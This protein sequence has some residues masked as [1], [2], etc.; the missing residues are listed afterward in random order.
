MGRLALTRGYILIPASFSFVQK[1]FLGLFS[2]F[3]SEHPVTKLKTKRI[4]LN[5]LFMLLHLNS[6]FALTL[7]YL[8]PALNNSALYSLWAQTYF[9]SSLL[10]TRKVRI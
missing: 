2:L 5:L 10:S 1:H 9:R 8:N 4:K 6:N 3:F 7:D